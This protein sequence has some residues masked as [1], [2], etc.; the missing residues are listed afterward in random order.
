MSTTTKNVAKAIALLSDVLSTEVENESWVEPEEVPDEEDTVARVDYE[1]IVEKASDFSSQTFDDL[2]DLHDELEGYVEDDDDD[3]TPSYYD[4]DDDDDDEDDDTVPG[5]LNEGD[6]APTDTVT[7][8]VADVAEAAAASTDLVP[9]SDSD[10]VEELKSKV[11]Q[12]E[13]VIVDTVDTLNGIIIGV[14]D[15]RNDTENY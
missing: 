14:E 2:S 3:C 9:E 11:A 1:D 7:D 15:F 8:D 10:E 12:L 4:D 6:V 5:H 13:G